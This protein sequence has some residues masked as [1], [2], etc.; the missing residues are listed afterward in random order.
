MITTKPSKINETV[1][2]EKCRVFFGRKIGFDF[3]SIKITKKK[4]QNKVTSN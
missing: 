4:K 1:Q 3:N 2:L